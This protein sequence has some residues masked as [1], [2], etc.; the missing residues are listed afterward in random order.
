MFCQKCGSQNEEGVNFCANC[1]TSLAAAAVPPQPAT[2]QPIAPP[3]PAPV[4]PPQQYAS[5]QP[6]YTQPQYSQPQY[7]PAQTAPQYAPPPVYAPPAVPKK[8]KTGLIAIAGVLLLAVVAVV[9][10][11]VF[12]GGNAEDAAKGYL[13]AVFDFDYAKAEKYSFI[14]I[15]K[16]FEIEEGLDAGNLKQEFK[17]AKEDAYL[18]LE[19]EFGDNAKITVSV[20]DSEVLEGTEKDDAIS[21]YEA[22]EDYFKGKI[23]SVTRVTVLLEVKGDDDEDSETMDI[24][25]VKSGSKWYVLNGLD[26]ISDFLIY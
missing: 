8:K 16:Y 10:V 1:G 25:A 18:E 24:I 11:F 12:T 19:N 26:F 20:T 14:D 21:T 2:Q 9:L 6:T 17:D 13:E 4:T 15:E 7:V 23:K 5:P 3:S 22:D